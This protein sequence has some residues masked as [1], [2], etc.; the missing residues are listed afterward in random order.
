VLAQLGNNLGNRGALLADGDVDT[1]NIATLLVDDRIDSYGGL[2]GLTVTNDQFALSTSDWNH[3]VNC[4]EA[5]SHWLMNRFTVYDAGGLDLN[6]AEAV[7]V[8]RAFAVDGLSDGVN[9]TANQCVA[10]RNFGDAAGTLNRIALFN[11]GELTENSGADVIF[12]QV[13][14]HTGYA[15]GKLQQLTGHGTCQAVDTGNTV[16]DGDD[17]AGFRHL[18]LLAILLD[19]F[20]D[21]LADLFG[22]DFHGRIY[23]FCNI[24]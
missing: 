17:C 7:G 19:L 3:G 2:A 20:S 23:P 5:G 1:D 11:L 21:D 9:N 22:S 8:D 15:A 13:E 18:N 6:L 12:F 14:N 16:T 4:L 24:S 10:Y